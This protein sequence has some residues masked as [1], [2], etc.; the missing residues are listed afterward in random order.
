MK[1]SET[2]VAP[3]SASKTSSNNS[4]PAGTDTKTWEL[5]AAGKN[6]QCS[7]ARKAARGSTTSGIKLPRIKLHSPCLVPYPGLYQPSVLPLIF[8]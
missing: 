6:S 7:T 3:S 5:R 2:E 8:A 4:S 1:A